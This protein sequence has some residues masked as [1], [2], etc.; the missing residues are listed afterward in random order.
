[1]AHLTPRRYTIPEEVAHS[2]IHALG[3]HLGAAMLALMV[4]FG[5]QSGE[6][7]AWKVVS[8][9][10]FGFSIILLYTVSSAY[11][12][13]T[14]PRTKQILKVCDHMAIYIL[15]AGSYTPFML[16]TLRP[17]YP[18]IAWTIFGIVWGL[19]IMG[20]VFKVFFT[21]RLRLVSTLAYV[22]MG[23]IIVFAI[24][25]LMA[26]LPAA[27]LVWLLIGGLCY[28][29]GAIFY[30]WRLMPFH[31]AVWHLCVLAGTLCHFFAVLF[32][33]MM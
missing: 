24:K 7:V 25:P 22:G 12:A 29:L 33:V 1:M 6:Q 31:H 28:T 26:T 27:G 14:H 18:V 13:I 3:S 9:A 4:V 19:T 2:A 5:V 30:L 32:Y 15:I 21:G 8:A 23:W 20:I 17:E 11:H 10:L 16:V